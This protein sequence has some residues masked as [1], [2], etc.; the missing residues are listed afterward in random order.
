MGKYQ[1]N[2]EIP[3]VL[4]RPIKLEP[5]AQGSR[6]PKFLAYQNCEVNRERLQILNGPSRTQVGM[7]LIETATS[8]R[9]V[10]AIPRARGD[11]TEV[12]RED[13]SRE[14]ELGRYG[15]GAGSARARVGIIY[16]NCD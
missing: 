6:F 2:S 3:E 5:T 16:E 7:S 1:I 14:E 9:Q 10:A 12:G 15:A 8:L 11:S 13:L 4:Q